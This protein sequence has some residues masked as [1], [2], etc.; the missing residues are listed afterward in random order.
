MKLV[1]EAPWAVEP[2]EPRTGTHV[3]S[4]SRAW[5]VRFEDMLASCIRADS[6]RPIP[7]AVVGRA[8]MRVN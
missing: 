7:L 5:L 3:A 2:S 4:L 6:L 1:T 8:S